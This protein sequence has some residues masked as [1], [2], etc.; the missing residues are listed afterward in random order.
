MRV[1]SSAVRPAC[2][3]SRSSHAA[4]VSARSLRAQKKQRQKGHGRQPLGIKQL[5]K[6]VAKVCSRRS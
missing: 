2:S 1:S 3:H 5:A 4:R 6:P